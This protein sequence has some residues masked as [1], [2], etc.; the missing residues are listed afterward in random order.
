CEEGASMRPTRVVYGRKRSAISEAS[1]EDFD[2]DTIFDGAV[3][4]HWTGITPALSESCAEISLDACKK[5]K[6]L[7]L[8][9]SCDLNY[10]STLWTKD[11]ARVVMEKLVPYTDIV[12]T[13]IEQVD[14]VFGIHPEHA[15]SNGDAIDFDAYRSVS[16]QMH[17]KFGTKIVAYTTR[18]SISAS[19]NITGALI[20]DVASDTFAVS[21]N[22]DIRIVDRVGGGDAFAGA[23]I[24]CMANGFDLQKTVDYAEA[25]A[26]LKHTI[27]GDY[28][29]F[30]LA[31]VEALAT[32]KMTGRVQR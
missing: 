5:A 28:A 26:A 8:T 21:P 13:N 11:Q 30:T 25:A 2:W 19:D 9:V 29:R 6:E 12:I 16:R 4:F 22:Y 15:V 18:K 1:R 3:W 27:E 14:D 32:G 23:M 17:E 24:Y 20:Y 10:R 7:G 31:E